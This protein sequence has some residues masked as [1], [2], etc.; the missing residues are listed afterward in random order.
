M[1]ELVQ[2]LRAQLDEDGLW[3]TEASRQD[4]GLAAEGGVHWQWVD[5]ATDKEV[6][7]DPS[8]ERRVG[9]EAEAN[10]ALRSRETW[11]TGCGVGDLPQFAIYR[12]EDVPS[13][14]GGH[15]VRHDPARVL[16]EIDAKR[17][18]LADHPIVP[19][20]YPRARVGGQEVGGP[21]FP[22][23]CENC[24]VEHDTGEVHGFGYCLLWKALALPYADRPGYREEW[25]P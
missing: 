11:P 9:E 4:D 8:R 6:V 10:V 15:I 13:A 24:H 22:F 25:R 5:T 1:D 16:R 20:T 18:L 12:A 14:V 21:H 17:L 2:W 19:E 23:G 7:P 3:A